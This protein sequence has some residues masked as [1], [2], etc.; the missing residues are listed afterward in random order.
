MV[1]YRPRGLVTGFNAIC[2]AC[3]AGVPS[4]SLEIC[5]VNLICFDL[6][7]QSINVVLSMHIHQYLLECLGSV[8]SVIV[9]IV[10]YGKHQKIFPDIFLLSKVLSCA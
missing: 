4:G 7:Y 8:C 2:N 10:A 1:F 5:S 9:L 6:F 3:L